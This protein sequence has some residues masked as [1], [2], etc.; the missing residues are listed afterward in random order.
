MNNHPLALGG[1]WDYNQ[2]KNEIT[3]Q[4]SNQIIVATKSNHSRIMFTTLNKIESCG[5]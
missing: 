3:I 2:P 4:Y 5:S 1:H